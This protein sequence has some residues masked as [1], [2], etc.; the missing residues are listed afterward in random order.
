MKK[1]VIV[2]FSLLMSLLLFTGCAVNEMIEDVGNRDSLM[3]LMWPT[4]DPYH[5]AR[6]DVMDKDTIKEV[7][8]FLAKI[9]WD[10]DAKSDRP[11]PQYQIGNYQ[12]WMSDQAHF[13]HAVNLENEK[14]AELTTEESEFV[15]SYIARVLH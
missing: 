14:Y 6:V 4:D 8:D 13:F 7:N 3:F 12:I 15:L 9:N 11:T 10:E 5:K 2:G 1:R